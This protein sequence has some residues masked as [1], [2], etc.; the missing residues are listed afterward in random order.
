MHKNFSMKSS[1]IQERFFSFNPKSFA[2]DAILSMQKCW[3]EIAQRVTFHLI[4]PQEFPADVS[5]M[6]N[7]EYEN[8]DALRSIIHDY[9]GDDDQN[10][11]NQIAYPHNVLRNAARKGA[12]TQF[13]FLI[14]VDVMPRKC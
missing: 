9:G 13:V 6:G 4:F 8:C 10:Y 5:Q 1:L 12:A 3:P 2:T 11:K 7:L 14:D